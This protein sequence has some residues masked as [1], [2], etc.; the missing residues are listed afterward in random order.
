MTV[1]RATEV[2]VRYQAAAHHSTD[3]TSLYERAVSTYGNLMESERLL[4]REYDDLSTVM[5]TRRQSPLDDSGDWIPPVTLH[6]RLAN[7]WGSI[8]DAI[9]YRLGKHGLEYEYVALT[10]YTES[11][12]TPHEHIVLWI[13]DSN[14]TVNRDMLQPVVSKHV[15]DVP[16][17]YEQH[18]RAGAVTVQHEPDTV[19][20][21]AKVSSILRQSD[22]TRD[23]SVPATTTV[24]QYV[25][26]QHPHLYLGHVADETD[27]EHEH[28]YLDTLLGGGATAWAS[29]YKTVTASR[30]ISLS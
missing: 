30:G 4:K 14:D 28:E 6:G 21:P 20:L 10:A 23:R 18:H 25:A 16:T 2:Y 12:A 26:S 5:L 9:N 29:P 3:R 22:A 8:R 19:D 24:A 7:T 1:E 27:S 17:A 15:A 13:D 11:C